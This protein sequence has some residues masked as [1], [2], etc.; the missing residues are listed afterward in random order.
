MELMQ[1]SGQSSLS[2]NKVQTFIKR[3]ENS[4]VLK[5][6]TV[7][8]AVLLIAGGTFYFLNNH[9]SANKVASK[10]MPCSFFTL[11]DAKLLLGKNASKGGIA[12]MSQVSSK[13]FTAENCTYTQSAQGVEGNI[14]LQSIK[15]AS[16]VV[17]TTKT[18]QANTFV[19]FLFSQ[20]KPK[21]AQDL[22]GYGD[23]AY[24]DPTQGVLYVKKD[25]KFV[26]VS[27]GVASP[28]TSRTLGDTKK[29]ADLVIPKL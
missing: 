24:W 16:V 3:I 29:L 6:L 2:A 28:A 8:L 25:N 22:S 26:T 23:K 20:G 5:I 15:T 19:D 27:Y 18:A 9:K 1:P 10:P 13:D 12:P 14:G 21:S 11:D 17:R 4:N 7:A